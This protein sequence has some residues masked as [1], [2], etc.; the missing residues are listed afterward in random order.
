MQYRLYEPADIDSLVTMAMALYEEDPGGFMSAEQVNATIAYALAHPEQLKIVVF[1]DGPDIVGYA[2]ALAVWSSEWS[3]IMIH[4]DE[5][6][7][8]PRARGRSWSRR[9][10]ENLPQ[11][12]SQ[13]V[14]GI[15][16]E[17]TPANCLAEQVY[18][19]LG[20]VPSTNRH[21]IKML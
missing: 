19:R 21:W 4:V 14:V 9:F 5:M 15:T 13:P 12:F 17:T 18:R 16:L 7:I 20:F 11:W 2:L 1:Q 3:G 6:Y 10:M 8:C